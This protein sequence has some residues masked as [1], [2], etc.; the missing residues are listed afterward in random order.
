MT[1]GYFR[2]TG[3]AMDRAYYAF[4]KEDEKPKPK[5]IKEKPIEPK[6]IKLLKAWSSYGR[7]KWQ[8]NRPMKK[9]LI[10]E[11]AELL[12]CKVEE[13]EGHWVMVPVP[14]IQLIVERLNVKL[15][16]IKNDLT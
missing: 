5:P 1:R 3:S 7:T 16:K 11:L 13:F 2:V 4:K 9:D 8:K 15:N 14:F 10:E 6:P 12:D